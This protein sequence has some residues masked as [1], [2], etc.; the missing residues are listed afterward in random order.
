LSATSNTIY[1]KT[2]RFAD[3]V[4]F[5]DGVEKNGDKESVEDGVA[6]ED[7]LDFLG[8]NNN[9]NNHIAGSTQSITKDYS[10]TAMNSTESYSTDSESEED[11]VVEEEDDES[12]KD[13]EQEKQN[14][15]SLLFGVLGFGIFTV[16]TISAKKLISVF[17][18][19]SNENS[20]PDHRNISDTQHGPGSGSP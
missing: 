11:D 7:S 18:K 4:K 8:N 6:N 1:K 15:K 17:S 16:A 14:V 5:A 12:D 9:S 3:S 2:I 13:K 20:P 10:P 19:S